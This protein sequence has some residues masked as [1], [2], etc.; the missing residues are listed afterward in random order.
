MLAADPCSNIYLR[1]ESSEELDKKETVH[2]PR[3]T[4]RGKKRCRWHTSDTSVTECKQISSFSDKILD[5]SK[6]KR[7][8]ENTLF[9]DTSLRYSDFSA[10]NIKEIKLV[11]SDLHRSNLSN[12]DF[13]GSKLEKVYLNRSNITG[14]NIKNIK[15]KIATYTGRTYLIRMPQRVSFIVQVYINQIYQI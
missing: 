6:I 4:A 2:C 10:S 1:E 7:L 5:K 14:S 12:S 3:N 13:S 8:K 9:T 11:N 15:I